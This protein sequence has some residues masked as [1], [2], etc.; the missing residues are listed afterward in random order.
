LLS[1][2][3]KKKIKEITAKDFSYI[4]H[5]NY[6]NIETAVSTDVPPSRWHNR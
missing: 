1:E 5:F 6:V 4:F 3:F 2:E